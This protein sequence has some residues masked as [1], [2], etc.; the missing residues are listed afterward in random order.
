MSS[1]PLDA[2]GSAAKLRKVFGPEELVQVLAAF[3]L[4]A[5]GSRDEVGLVDV[6]R[7]AVLIVNKV[8]LLSLEDE[9]LVGLQVSV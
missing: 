4:A 5:G 7:L 1:N 6:H 9:G 3:D 8:D 2:A